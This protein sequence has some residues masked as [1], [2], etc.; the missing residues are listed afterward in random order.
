[1]PPVPGGF[2][3]ACV[4]LGIVLSGA[5]ATMAKVHSPWILSEHVADTRDEAR[6]AADPR[7]AGLEGQEKAL[8]VWRYLT[9]RETGTWH[10]GDVYEGGDPHWESKLVKD[11]AK[12]LNVY[13]FGVCTAHASMIEGLYEAMGFGVRQMEFGGYHRTAEVEWDGGP[14]PHSLGDG[15][16]HYLD[17]DERA[18]LVDE[19]GRVVSVTEATTRPEL[20]ELSSKQVVPFYP[21]NGGIKG[22]QELSKHGPSVAHWHWR[23]LGHSMDFTLRPGESLTRYWQPQ[24]RWRMIEGWDGEGTREWLQADPAGPKTAAGISANNSYGNGLWVYEPK[25]GPEYRD[26]E[27]GVCRQRNVKV[28]ARGVTLAA[29]GRG[30]VEWR[31]RTPYVIAGRPNDLADPEDDSGAAVVEF[32]ASG[33]VELSVSTDAGRHWTRVWS[34]PRAQAKQRVDLTRWVQ[35]RYEYHVRFGM[36]GQPGAARLGSLKITT[37]TQLAPASLPRLKAGV[38]HLRYVSGDKHGWPT[39]AVA[40]E[41]ELSDPA[42]AKRWGVHVDGQYTPEDRTLR[43][44]GPVTLRVDALAGTKLRWLHVGASFNARRD[45]REQGLDRILYSLRPD[46]GWRVLREDAPPSWNEHWYYNAEAELVLERPVKSVWLKLEPATAANG[47]RIYLHCQP[48]S[49][50]SSP[51][52]TV[53]HAYRLEGRLVTKTFRLPRPRDYQITCEGEP[54]NVCVRMAVPSQR[55]G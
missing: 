44:R 23:T 34:S 17:V 52:L 19:T 22:I 41:P 10:Y 4:L 15:A 31:V 45:G 13:G 55:R 39:E 1:M 53:T 21:Q 9:D 35:G 14:A 5:T 42:D 18:Y 27:Q 20:W 7:W 46:G 48:D 49:P 51:P 2:T 50:P 25:L 16:W 43:A 36:H 30:W 26:F 40:I 29:A 33:P 12:I 28:T 37:W 11:P 8:A 47:L 3:K 6:F 54:E 32:A 38:N 24:G